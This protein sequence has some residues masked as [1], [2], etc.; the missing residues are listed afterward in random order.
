MSNQ[1]DYNYNLVTGTV[2]DN[3][4]VSHHIPRSD[5]QYSWI[6]ASIL[7]SN[8]YPEKAQTFGHAPANGIVSSSVEGF[9]PAYNFVSA[10]DFGSYIHQ[11]T[12]L[13]F[14]GVHKSAL[15][16]HGAGDVFGEGIPTDFVGLN[17]NIFEPVSSSSNTLGYPELTMVNTDGGDTIQEVNYINQILFISYF[18]LFRKF[19]IGIKISIQSFST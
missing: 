14:F 13:R 2:Y 15:K 19:F 3:Y 18:L 1:S 11:G 7:D 6:T 5:L 17:S 12:G 16:D 8:P 9:V 4:W 10:S